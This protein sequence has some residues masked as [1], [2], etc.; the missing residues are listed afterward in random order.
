MSKDYIPQQ[1]GKILQESYSEMKQIKQL[2]LF[3]ENRTGALAEV[4]DT[5]RKAGFNIRTLTLADTQ[6]FGI[7]RLLVDDPA[8]AQKALESAG[9]TAKVTEVMAIG[10]P[11]RAGGLADL[12]AVFGKHDLAVEYMYAFAAGNNERAVMIFRFSDQD[13]A[14]AALATEEIEILNESDLI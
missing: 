10:V 13:A 8:G 6:Q 14:M 3:V 7:L 5:I 1:T 11:H 2:S 12:L 4:C 9:M